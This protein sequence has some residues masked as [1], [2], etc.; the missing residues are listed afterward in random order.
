MKHLLSAWLIFLA[1]DFASVILFIV[2]MVIFGGPI[3]RWRTAR[4]VNSNNQ[5]SFTWIKQ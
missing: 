4:K 1:I 2:F 5:R 3:S